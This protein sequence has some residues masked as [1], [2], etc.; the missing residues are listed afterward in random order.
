MDAVVAVDWGGTWVRAA[1]VEGSSITAGPHKVRRPAELDKQ[2]AVVAG[3]AERLTTEAGR[4][5]AG[6]GVGVGGI[7]RH[8]GVVLSASN[9]GLS[10]VD[11]RSVLASRL[12][13]EVFVVN[14]VQAA[15][16][17]EAADA[18]PG[19][20]VVLL[21]VGTGVGAAIVHNGHLVRGRGA[22]GD[23]GH[24]VILMGGP[25][26][27][28]GGRGCLEQ[29]VSGRVLD[30][31]ARRLVMDG[32][33]PVLAA[34]ADKRTVHGGDLDAAARQGDEGARS[35]LGDAVTALVA[36]L[37]AVAAACDPDRVVLGGGTLG[38]AT[39]LRGL[40][41]GAWEEQRPPWTALELGAPRWGDDA[42]LVGVSQLVRAQSS[43]GRAGNCSG[44]TAGVSHCP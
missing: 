30:D 39:Y 16:L 35:V 36:G 26:C 32:R 18:A 8:D 22:A 17:A 5:V 25:E 33:S 20:T 3:L 4:P 13:Q 15:A 9:I 14:D 42:G 19:S 21:M 24:T 23:F 12:H 10:G 44:A 28:C 29:L 6:V 40:V 34:I 38:P 2:F 41:H 1:L 7:V 37:R 11:V 43:S 31:A 27:V